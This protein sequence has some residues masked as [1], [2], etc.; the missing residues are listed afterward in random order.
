MKDLLKLPAEVLLSA[1]MLGMLL[2]M[3]TS[4]VAVKPFSPRSIE[5]IAA[6]VA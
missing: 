3:V 6:K 2:P 1:P 5:A 4:G